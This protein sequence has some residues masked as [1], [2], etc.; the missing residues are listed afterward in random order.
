MAIK[1]AVGGRGNDGV[2]GKTVLTTSGAPSN[3][4]GTNGDYAYDPT[5]KLMYGPKAAGVWPAG[6]SLKGSLLEVYDGAYNAA[7]AYV[8]GRVVTRQGTTYMAKTDGAPVGNNSQHIGTTS[9]A[10]GGAQTLALPAG[11]QVGDTAIFITQSAAAP[12][13]SPAGFT[14]L[15]AGSNGSNSYTTLRWRVLASVADLTFTAASAGNFPVAQV[16]TFRN[17]GAPSFTTSPLAVINPATYAAPADPA[18]TPSTSKVFR[19]WTMYRGS[20]M[21]GSGLNSFTADSGTNKTNATY[22]PNSGTEMIDSYSADGGTASLSGLIVGAATGGSGAV[23]TMVMSGADGFDVTKWELL[24]G[25]GDVGATGPTGAAGPTGASGPTVAPVVAQDFVD[26]TGWTGYQG[27]NYT[28]ATPTVSGSKLVPVASA[29]EQ[30]V[31]PVASPALPSKFRTIA[32]VDLVTKAAARTYFA[33]NGANR[34]YF[35]YYD[36]EANSTLTLLKDIGGASTTLGT[37]FVTTRGSGR[38]WLVSRRN[39][40]YVRCEVWDHEP[41]SLGPNDVPMRF[42]DHTMDATTLGQFPIANTTSVAVSIYPTT[43]GGYATAIESFYAYPLTSETDAGPVGATGPAGNSNSP[44][45]SDDFTTDKLATEYTT[46]PAAN[47]TVSSGT[48]KTAVNNT[49]IILQKTG[50]YLA[51]DFMSTVKITPGATA[52][53]NSNSIGFISG[54]N[55]LNALTDAFLVQWQWYDGVSAASLSGYDYIAGASTASAV[56]SGMT[57]PVTGVP[58]WLRMTKIGNTPTIGYFT[59]DPDATPAP[60]AAYTLTLSDFFNTVARN[61]RRGA[62]ASPKAF[63]LYINLP[64]DWLVDDY[65]V[66]S[67]SSA[68][69]KGETGATGPAPAYP[70]LTLTP[71]PSQTAEAVIAKFLIPAGTL[72]VGRTYELE[73]TFDTG[74][75]ATEFLKLR[76]GPLGT[77]ADPEPTGSDLT[78]T[79]TNQPCGPYKVSMRVNA[80]GAGTAGKVSYFRHASFNGNSSM[81]Y[82]SRALNKNIDTTVDNWVSITAS[83]SSAQTHD[84]IYTSMIRTSAL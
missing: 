62:L 17:V 70:A 46:T 25:K 26:L 53:G 28:N 43:V 14:V 15:A 6:V 35:Q 1:A 40:K 59:S 45:W 10:G 22:T 41:Y 31:A 81:V 32:V 63:G 69:S 37:H 83:T 76:V 4:I 21:S 48:L 78:L 80:L 54:M 84:P 66:H 61:A 27:V 82:P 79:N 74:V 67:L 50:Q 8:A 58:F 55:V 2:D 5:A 11:T 64:A 16:A 24:A 68:G 36:D 57:R 7:N 56:Q 38:Y 71:R 12:T 77:T 29:S 49:G 44:L 52:G 51:K 34:L 30:G 19:V 75:G 60:S 18:S 47:L 3:G 65:K 39:G 42:I 9:V 13:S 23:S 20:G 72:V 73:H 33:I